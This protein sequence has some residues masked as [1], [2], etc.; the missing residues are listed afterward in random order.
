VQKAIHYL[1]NIK[2]PENETT[3]KE[4]LMLLIENLEYRFKI[5]DI[6]SIAL[7]LDPFTYH[8][9]IDDDSTNPQQ[10][11]WREIKKE[12]LISLKEEIHK[13]FPDMPQQQNLINENISQTQTVTQKVQTINVGKREIDV[14]FLTEQT[15]VQPKKKK[16]KLN[17]KK[18][19]LNKNLIGM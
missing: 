15:V 4:I 17:L 9:I 16:L 13:R 14:S 3:N 10:E 5:T 18:N 19:L 2:V 7:A 6:N 11:E 1:N 8:E 12:A